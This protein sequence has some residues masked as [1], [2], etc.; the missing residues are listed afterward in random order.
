MMTYITHDCTGIFFIIMF[1]SYGPP[2]LFSLHH[3]IIIIISL[4][5]SL[6]THTHTHTHIEG[7]SDQLIPPSHMK[8]LFEA[9]VRSRRKEFY[10]VYGG[11]HNDC[12]EVAGRLVMMV[13]V[14]VVMMMMMMVIMII[15]MMIIVMI[16]MTRRR[17]RIIER[18]Y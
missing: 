4:F 11:T 13:M 12:M 1:V 17:R 3:I 18:I 10:S 7:D 14:V 15:I 5:F 6:H 9:A 8:A 2:V 16:T